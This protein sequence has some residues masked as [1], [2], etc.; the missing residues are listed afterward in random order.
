VCDD[1][2]VCV[3]HCSINEATPEHFSRRMIPIEYKP[4]DYIEAYV[5]ENI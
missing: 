4:V 2:N 1:L 3:D 5:D